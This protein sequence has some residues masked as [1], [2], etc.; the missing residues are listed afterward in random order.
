MENNINPDFYSFA[1][2]PTNHVT[3]LSDLTITI[4]LGVLLVFFLSF[5]LQKLL[6]DKAEK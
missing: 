2:A 4:A 6:G 3:T 5:A 1:V